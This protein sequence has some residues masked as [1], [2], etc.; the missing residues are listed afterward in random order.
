M[1]R[2]GE[3]FLKTDVLIGRCLN[4]AAPIKRAKIEEMSTL[5]GN[6]CIKQLKDKTKG[7]INDRKNA[8]QLIDVILCCEVT[9]CFYHLVNNTFY[10][11]T[12]RLSSLDSRD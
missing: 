12:S 5:K 1:P 9:N 11:F 7:I 8:N 2:P 6:D 4:M 3:N 10:G